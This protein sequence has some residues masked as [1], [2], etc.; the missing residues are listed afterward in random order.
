MCENT[1]TLPVGGGSLI[2]HH[3]E[4]CKIGVTLVSQGALRPGLNQKAMFTHWSAG[5]LGDRIVFFALLSLFLKYEL[6]FLK[7]KSFI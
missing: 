7:K 6:F 1:F 4:M 5:P 3:Q 2:A